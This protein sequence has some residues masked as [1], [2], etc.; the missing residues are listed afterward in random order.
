MKKLTK[1]ELWEAFQNGKRLEV[2]CPWWPKGHW[3]NCFPKNEKSFF[4]EC[5]Y[6]IKVD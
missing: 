6:R 4:D 2:N 5:S 3:E 1:K